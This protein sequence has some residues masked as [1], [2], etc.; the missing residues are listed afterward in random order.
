MSY[1]EYTVKTVPSGVRKVLYLNWPLVLLLVAVASVGFLMLYSVAGGS[2][3]PWVEPQMKRFALGLVAMFIVALV[4][5]WFWRNMA[6]VAYLV[7][8]AL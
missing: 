7:S 2:F 1:L 8:L 4:P 3:R 6:A 5:I